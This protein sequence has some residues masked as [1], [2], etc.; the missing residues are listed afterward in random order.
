MVLFTPQALQ[1]S[2]IF[3]WTELNICQDV[4]RLIPEKGTDTNDSYLD[5][6]ICPN[7]HTKV[8]TYKNIKQN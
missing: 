8:P 4:L 2:D 1:I 3:N 6:K 7:I 5:E